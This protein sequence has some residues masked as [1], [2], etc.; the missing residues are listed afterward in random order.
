MVAVNPDF[1]S[2]RGGEERGK[3]EEETQKKM[4][5]PLLHCLGESCARALHAQFEQRDAQMQNTFVGGGSVFAQNTNRFKVH[6]R[7]WAQNL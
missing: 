4:E 2:E 7:V 3:E 6:L 1:D 5:T